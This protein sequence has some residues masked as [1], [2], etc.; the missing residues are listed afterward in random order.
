MRVCCVRVCCVRV[1][2][3][4]FDPVHQVLVSNNTGAFTALLA[5]FAMMIW[6]LVA[7]IFVEPVHLGM[8][9]FWMSAVSSVILGAE[10]SR[11]PIVRLGRALELLESTQSM[12]I[13]GACAPCCRYWLSLLA[14]A[15]G[16]SLLGC[17]CG[18]TMCLMCWC[19]AQR[20]VGKRPESGRV[21][22]WQS[23]CACRH[24]RVCQ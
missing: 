3:V 20:S 7:T 22:T 11:R 8:G 1:W 12:R 10:A 6:G 18:V 21:M 2:L 19:A 24:E 9:V 15:I 14:V 5:F 23:W 13:L 4:Q 16:L 17:S